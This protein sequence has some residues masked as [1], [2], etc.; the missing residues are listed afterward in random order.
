MSYEESD[1]EFNTLPTDSDEYVIEKV[2]DLIED[3]SENR[4][5]SIYEILIIFAR[6]SRLKNEGDIV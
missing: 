5:L 4:T 2:R 3:E 6:F 1:T